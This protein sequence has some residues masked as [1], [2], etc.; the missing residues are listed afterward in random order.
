M[1][2]A[3]N[4]TADHRPAS[5]FAAS[6]GC[7]RATEL[8]ARHRTY[9]QALAEVLD[10]PAERDAMPGC[11]MPDI[12]PHYP[13]HVYDADPAAYAPEV[14]VGERNAVRLA[15]LLGFEAP[16]PTGAA[17]PPA[18][19]GD[20]TTAAGQEPA[21]GDAG[22]MPAE[23]FLGRVLAALALTPE[24]VGV[25]GYFR[26]RWYTGGRSA[27]YLQQRLLELHDLAQWCAARGR[28]VV[29]G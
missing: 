16:E 13:L 20:T 27:G 1:T 24:D 19:A 18:G 23:Q 8:A 7:R 17:T 12:C 3:V 6:C 28:D 25:D 9:E 11:A 15:H 5:A 29:W 4:F 26:G 10:A 14:N 21:A 22:Q 2:V